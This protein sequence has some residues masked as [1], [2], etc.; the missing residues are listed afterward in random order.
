[1]WTDPVS[2]LFYQADITHNYSGGPVGV[3]KGTE[4][5]AWN[6]LSNTAYTFT[7]KAV[8]GGSSGGKTVSMS[9]TQDTT[10]PGAVSGLSAIDG[11]FGSVE[12]NWDNPVDTDLQYVEITC[13]PLS[14]PAQLVN[15]SAGTPGTYTW[16]GLAGGVTYTFTVTAVDHSGNKSPGVSVSGTPLDTTPPGPVTSLVS[17]YGDEYAAFFWTDPGDADLD[18]IQIECNEIPGPARNVPKGTRPYTWTGLPNGAAYTFTVKA[19]DFTGN[20]STAVTT[21]PVTPHPILY[22]DE[23]FGVGA[24]VV[25]VFVVYDKPTW[26]TAL[27]V[28]T[29]NGNDQ[30]YGVDVRGNVIGLGAGNFGGVT[31]LT[32]SLR[33]ETGSGESL[34]LGSNGSQVTVV[35]NQTLILRDLTL[36]GAGGSGVIVGGAAAQ[37]IMRNGTITG[38][39]GGGVMVNPGGTF[40]MEDGT[41]TGNTVTYNGG[42][43]GVLNGTFYMKGGVISNNHTAGS[44]GGVNIFSGTGVFIK[45]GGTLYGSNG[46]PNANTCNSGH[47]HAVFK[48]IAPVKERNITA[49]PGDNINSTTNTGF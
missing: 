24:S 47:G 48:N 26:E 21:G 18:Y 35:A 3:P 13:D 49:G 25:G 38:N 32:V 37:F 17:L 46:G 20:R 36:R 22:S 16:T 2:S 42:G 29:G 15:V 41:I 44:G 9:L 1:S 39:T 23:D 6:G 12:L 40:T 19:V 14:G 27:A 8:A 43:V 10:P 45:T 28:I 31:G 4:Q 30:K 34:A 11:G 5:S 33:G 7:V